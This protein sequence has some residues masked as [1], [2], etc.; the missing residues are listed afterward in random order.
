MSPKIR[1]YTILSGEIKV[2]WNLNKV[3]IIPIIVGAMGT[4]CNKLDEN[5]LRL[6]LANHKFQVDKAQNIV[7]LFTGHIVRSFL[8]LVY[9]LLMTKLQSNTTKP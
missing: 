8:Q 1:A 3:Q 2:L 4:F 9:Y 7:L 6:G 5:I